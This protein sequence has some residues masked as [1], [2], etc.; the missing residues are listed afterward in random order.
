MTIDQL[1]KFLQ[2][3][4]IKLGGDAPV[5]ASWDDGLT[6]FEY[7]HV[8]DGVLVLDVPDYSRNTLRDDLDYNKRTMTKRMVPE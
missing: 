7:Y 6:D 5:V 4:S 1:I 3:Q 8:V 2:Q